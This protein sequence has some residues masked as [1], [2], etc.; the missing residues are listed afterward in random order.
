MNSELPELFQM[1]QRASRNFMR[2][3]P[4]IDGFFRPEEEHGRSGK[5]EIVPPMG[6]G[7][8]E[9]RDIRF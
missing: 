8:G 9:V 2:C 5:D 7:D 6:G 1:N 3:A 4:L